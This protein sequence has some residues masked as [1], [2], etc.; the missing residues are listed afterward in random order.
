MN[1][2]F[3]IEQKFNHFSPRF[4]KWSKTNRFKHL[5]NCINFKYNKDENFHQIRQRERQRE[6]RERETPSETHSDHG[7][8]RERER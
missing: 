4:Y 8:E 7:R 2:L 5:F 3:R 6:E 1:N